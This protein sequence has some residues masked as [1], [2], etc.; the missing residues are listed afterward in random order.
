M[1]E[2]G[3][4]QVERARVTKHERWPGAQHVVRFAAPEIAARA[5]PGSFVHMDCGPQWLLRRP[6]S[7]MSAAQGEI[8]VLFKE[9]GHGTLTLAR[10]EA[11]EETELI[12]PIGNGFA[13]V[14]GRPRRVL[15]GGGV[16]IPPMIYFAETL[17]AAGELPP[18]GSPGP[19]PRSEEWD[20][21]SP[22]PCS[23]SEEGGVGERFFPL[24]LAG[25]ELPLPF[26]LQAATLA[27]GS[28]EA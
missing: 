28:A 26:E 1:P 17:V 24:V 9:V 14:A 23:R 16:G 4:I 5:A 8:E 3:P 19:R 11:G 10:L 12:G 6:M 20:N 25:S 2:A 15:I 21:T 13:P 7:L 22:P 18:S 27:A